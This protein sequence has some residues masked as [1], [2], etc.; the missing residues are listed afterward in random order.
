MPE[1][2]APDWISGNDAPKPANVPLLVPDRCTLRL[3]PPSIL[4]AENMTVAKSYPAKFDAPVDPLPL[5]RPL[6]AVQI[7]I[8][9]PFRLSIL[10]P[11]HLERQ[12]RQSYCHSVQLGRCARLSEQPGLP[13]RRYTRRCCCCTRS[14]TS[15][16]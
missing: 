9:E 14:C 6:T 1:P 10:S 16:R 7:F 5:G 4:P 11:T 13:W 15:T 12:R 3:I 8:A 2:E